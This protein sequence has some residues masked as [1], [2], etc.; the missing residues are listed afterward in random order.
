MDA[1]EITHNYRRLAQRGNLPPVGCIECG[2]D[3]TVT[4][5]DDT[6]PAWYCWPCDRTWKPGMESLQL[7]SHAISFGYNKAMFLV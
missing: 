6:E 5:V 7:M 3:M 1:W 4:I 2:L